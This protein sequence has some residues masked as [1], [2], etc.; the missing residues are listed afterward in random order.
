MASRLLP[1]MPHSSATTTYSAD[2]T[3]AL[4]KKSLEGG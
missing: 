3:L 4:E 1:E 2:I